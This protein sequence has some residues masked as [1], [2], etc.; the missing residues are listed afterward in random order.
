[1]IYV[2]GCGSSS[3]KLAVIG[4][5][6]GYYEEL[7]G[8][9][10]AGP[11]G[12]IL[13]EMLLK[14]GMPRENI[15]ASNVVKVR[16]PQNNI[17]RL[18]EYGKSIEDFEPQLWDELEALQPNCILALG[19][20]PLETLTGYKGITHHRGSIHPSL[21]GGYKVISTIHPAA[22][23]HGEAEGEGMY[24][25]KDQVYIQWDVN[26]AIAQSKFRE[27]RRPDRHLVIA[28]NSLDVY[29]FFD[30]FSSRKLVAVDIETFHTIP[31]CISF[32]FDRVNSISIPLFN[33]LSGQNEEGMTRSDI[34]QVWKDVAALLADPEIQ[35]IGQNFKFDEKLLWR[36]FDDTLFFGLKVRGFCF[37]TMLAFRTLYPELRG[38]LEFITSVLTEEPYYKEEGKGYNPKKDKL[39]RLLLYNAKDSVVTFEA[40]EEELREL[41]E[42]GLADFFFDKVMPLHPFY[43][44]LETRGIRRDN[45]RHKFLQEKYLL[46]QKELRQE[47]DELTSE[48]G[49][50]GVNVNSN[51]V[52][53]QVGKLIYGA[54][55]LPPRKGVDEKTLDALARNVA[56]KDKEKRILKLILELR[57]VNK[58]RG[59]YVNAEVLHDGKLHTSVKIMLE[60]GRTATSI[61]KPPVTTQK[62]GLAFQTITKHGD[63]GSDLRSMY[64]PDPGYMLIEPDLSQAEARVVAVLAKDEK[65]LKMFTF[66]VDIHRVTYNW[67]TPRYLGGLLGEFFEELSESRCREI[68]KL[69]NKELKSVMTDEERQIGKKFRHAG[70]YDMGKREAARQVGIPE[71]VAN[72][73]L[74]G[75]HKTNENIRKVFHEGIKK[76][77]AE[78]NRILRSPNGRE[79]Q[80]FNKWGEDL[81]KEAYAQIPQSTVTDQTKKAAIAVEKRCP[82]VEILLESHDSFLAQIPIDSAK[83]TYPVIVEEL[84]SP[85]DF[86][87]CS[88]SRDVDLIIPC[89]IKASLTNWEEMGL[90]II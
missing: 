16:P 38:R 9:P 6:P 27:I 40:Y 4:E 26:R 44:R 65:L 64:I 87:K 5:A 88:L 1:M 49:I 55:G 80:F 32:A 22:L 15:Y 67:I 13:D 54:M 53:G 68:A 24:S 41:H 71:I 73:I 7:Q 46:M 76:V 37:D 29:R 34:V 82:W 52:K 51:G 81:W 79:R 50:K 89:E 45:F 70:H 58:T 69:L 85:I 48:Y 47:L 10:F 21:R 39:S 14:G 28:K 25:W 11:T 35:K 62:Y 86:R 3:A 56:K 77:L 61:L 19:N 8:R 66:G 36:C 74:L 90:V 17:H 72:K 78:N 2:P 31:I 20:T 63:V 43:S 23:M 30:R 84:E 42:R 75:F 12:K 59:T 18:K 57:K 60:S 83:E 33:Q